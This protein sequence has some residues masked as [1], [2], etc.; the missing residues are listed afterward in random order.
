[1]R[2]PQKP[3]VPEAK[4]A[5]AQIS[6]QLLMRIVVLLIAVWSG[7]SGLV[8]LA[9]HGASAGALSA[10]INDEAG[11][12]LVGIH[13]VVLVPAY[14]LIAWRFERY[15]GMVW[16]PFA[17]QCCFAAV[18]LYSIVQD[19]TKFGDG[20]LAFAASA[21]LAGSLGV[22][23]LTEQRAVAQQKMEAEE[24]NARPRPPQLPT[25]GDRGGSSRH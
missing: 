20:I 12:R 7:F 22:L 8:L 5:D 17:A 10:G 21:L 2:E 19:E 4:P 24:A 16:L 23:W 6:A 13:M 9:F 11:Q 1:M 3:A 14:V 25:S 15:G 18:V